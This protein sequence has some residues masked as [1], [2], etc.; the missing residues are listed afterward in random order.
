MT[1]RL[2]GK[3]FR[4]SEE[5]HCLV[6]VEPENEHRQTVEPEPES[7]VRRAAVL[8]EFE[9]EFDVVAKSFFVR[10]F[11]QNFISVF[12]L[13]ARR[14]FDAAPDKVVALR[15][16]AFV[17]HMIE[18]AFFAAIV[19]YEQ[20]FVIIVFLHPVETQTFGFGG[21]IAFLAFRHGVTVV[22][23]QSVVKIFECNDGEGVSGRRV[24]F[25]KVL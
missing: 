25:R 13:R 20:E 23:F 3:S 21:K 8:E 7:A 11:F 2:R 14:D 4:A 19:G 12:A 24:R 18:R 22:F 17:A 5:E 10:L 15:H 9:I 1:I 16:A 6:D